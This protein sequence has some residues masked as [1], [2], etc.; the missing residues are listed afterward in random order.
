MMWVILLMIHLTTGMVLPGDLFVCCS[1]IS[2]C[3]SINIVYVFLCI[4]QPVVFSVC[5]QAWC[6]SSAQESKGKCLSGGDETRKSGARML[7]GALLSGGGGWDLPERR[8]NGTLISHRET[9]HR[10][11][12]VWDD[13][14]CFWQ[15]L[16]F[17]INLFHNSW[18][19]TV[20]S[21]RSVCWFLRTALVCVHFLKD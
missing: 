1:S 12:N 6:C 10:H 15:N 14:T 5:G 8:E 21:L 7:W 2:N 20:G 9:C 18:C 4:N 11:I 13:I 19:F 3:L 17:M 16:C